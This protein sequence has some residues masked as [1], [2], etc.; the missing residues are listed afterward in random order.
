MQRNSRST[1]VDRLCQRCQRPFRAPLNNVQRGF[2]LYCSRACKAGFR[3]AVQCAHC[4]TNFSVPASIYGN[5][6]R[7]FCSIFCKNA[8]QRISLMA[9][10]QRYTVSDSGC[11]EWTGTISKSGYPYCKWEGRPRRVTRLVAELQLGLDPSSTMVVCHRCD[12][13]RCIN[14]DHLFI[15]TQHENVLDCV[16]KRRHPHGETNGT[17]KLTEAWV[18]EIRR[19]AD[20]GADH[21]DLASEYKVSTLTIALVVSRQGWKH[22]T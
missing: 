2:G 3:V 22:V 19:R 13:R 1:G 4:Q 14:P 20:E 15:G 11:W 7:K 5:G 17:A 10:L 18:R 12:N 21:V 6:R 9:H 8:A 16:A